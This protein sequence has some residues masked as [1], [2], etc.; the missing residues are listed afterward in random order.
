MS[1]PLPVNSP[2]GAPGPTEHRRFFFCVSGLSARNEILLKSFVRLLQN[3][4]AQEWVYS[5]TGAD[6]VVLGSEHCA[7][8]SA[9]PEQE[10]V[11]APTQ[12]LPP[13]ATARLWVGNDRPGEPFTVPLPLH[14]KDVET[15]L[16]HIGVWLLANP[17]AAPAEEP[18]GA[19]HGHGGHRIDDHGN[20]NG[21]RNRNGETYQLLRWPPASFLCTLERKKAATL[22]LK[23]QL[24][25][26]TLARRSGMALAECEFFV[27]TLPFLK[28]TPCAPA[29]AA[30]SQALD[31]FFLPPP[32]DAGAGTA[33]G[34]GPLHSLPSRRA[35]SPAPAPAPAPAPVL[36]PASR[37]GTLLAR[38]RK[39]L[40]L[41]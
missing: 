28:T 7:A 30:D 2:A 39:Q 20:G 16:N 38:I 13:R 8:P 23:A 29:S 14:F 15:A 31:L 3:A 11:P 17:S 41:A 21:N 40:G 32:A 26:P 1:S 24:D 12:P 19:G 37:M 33:A 9:R 36:A 4:T 35:A 22:L 6:L 27:Q 18:S 25:L 34:E 5:P 10:T